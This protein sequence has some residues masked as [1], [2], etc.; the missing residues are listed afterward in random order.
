MTKSIQQ[1]I[2]EEREK[3]RLSKV[4]DATINR[5]LAND[6][7]RND[8]EFSKTMSKVATDRN[9]DPTYIENHLAGVRHN[10]DNTYQ[11]ET[12]SRQEVKEKISKA[13]K[14]VPKT[15]EA[16]KKYKEIKTN[17]YGDAKYEVA[18]KLGLAK[19]DRPF[20]AGEYSVMNN[21]QPFPSRSEAA[22][23]ALSKGLVNS[24]KKFETWTKTKPTEYYFVL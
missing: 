12:N 20:W 17:K 19:R 1:I 7:K 10:R 6:W 13:L 23:F 18:H 22:R 14:G 9:Q 21:N 3:S 8:P 4:S 24:V 11:A 16:K 5:T 15:E 2:D